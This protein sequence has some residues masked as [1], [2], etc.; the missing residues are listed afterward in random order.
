MANGVNVAE[1][2]K[3][4]AREGMSEGEIQEMAE[5]DLAA[6]RDDDKSRFRSTRSEANMADANTKAQLRGN[7]MKAVA[8][9]A[10]AGIGA[11]TPGPKTETPKATPVD[12]KKDMSS[13]NLITGSPSPR[14]QLSSTRKAPDIGSKD[15]AREK[16]QELRELERMY[17][18][19]GSLYGN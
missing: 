18:R 16:A 4:L 5:Q 19:R 10:V 15:Y 8:Q 17:G 7:M 11:G 12:L 14:L 3:A 2:Y 9:S 6:K 13:D 1:R